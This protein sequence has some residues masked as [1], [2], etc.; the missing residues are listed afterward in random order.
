MT[1]PIV[2]HYD[3]VSPYSH[4]AFAQR[5]TIRNRSG[6]DLAFRPVD[7]LKVM[8]LVG[9]VP[10]S[11]ICPPKRAYLG[12][13]LARWS[14]KLGVPVVMHPLLGRFPAAELIKAALQAGDDIEAFSAAAFAAVWVDAAPLDDAQA[15][16]DWFAAKDPR[17][18]TYWHNRDQSAEAYDAANAAAAAA[19]V[20]GVPFFSTPKGEFFGN[21]RVEAL[22]EEL[23]A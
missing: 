16:A 13:D 4:F 3:F 1:A 20:F 14:R 22:I 8:D 23:A 18:A 11:V 6:L 15:T 2:L 21:D 19:G 7:V 12:Q 17:F 9:N 10:T 5:E